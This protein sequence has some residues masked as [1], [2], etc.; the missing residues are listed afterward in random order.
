MPWEKIAIESNLSIYIFIFP[1]FGAEKRLQAHSGPA[2][3]SFEGDFYVLG[4]NSKTGQATAERYVHLGS[5][6]RMVGQNDGLSSSPGYVRWRIPIE[7][8]YR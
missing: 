5:P 8:K 7:K 2:A 4:T 3:A 6:G 1:S